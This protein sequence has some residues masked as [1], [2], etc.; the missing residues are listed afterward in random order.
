MEYMEETG[1]T[2]GTSEGRVLLLPGDDI[3]MFH[4]T[5]LWYDCTGN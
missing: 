2:Q 3:L 4:H 1:R 5:F